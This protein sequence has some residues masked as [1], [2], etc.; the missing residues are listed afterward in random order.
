MSEPVCGLCNFSTFH[1]LRTGVG[2]GD[3]EDEEQNGMECGACRDTPHGT[4]KLPAG[5]ASL[6]ICSA[7]LRRTHADTRCR[8]SICCHIGLTIYDVSAPNSAQAM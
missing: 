3:V 7:G 4:A 8:G 2:S 6:G 5:V 1:S